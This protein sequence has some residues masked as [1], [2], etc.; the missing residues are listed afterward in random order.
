M[1][2]EETDKYY[3]GETFKLALRKKK[4]AN[5]HTHLQKKLPLTLFGK[6]FENKKNVKV[7]EQIKNESFDWGKNWDDAGFFEGG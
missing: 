3:I 2:K 1:N 4:L 6:T 7:L 5:K